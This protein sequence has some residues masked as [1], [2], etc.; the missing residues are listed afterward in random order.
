LLAGPITARIYASSTTRN[1]ML[2]ATLIDVA[3]HGTTTSVYHIWEPDV[4]LLGTPA[5][6]TRA[7]A[8]TTAMA[9]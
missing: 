9:D 2:V 7:E 4:V 8:G 6:L 1:S 5:L 3:P